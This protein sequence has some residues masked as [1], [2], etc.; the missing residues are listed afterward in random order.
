MLVRVS[1]FGE[2]HR[3]AFPKATAGG[4]EFAAVAAAVTQVTDYSDSKVR[5]SEAGRQ[6]KARAR[7]AL[8][9]RLRSIGRTARIIARRTPGFADPFRIP[10]PGRPTDQAVLAAGRI[11]ADAAAEGKDRFLTHGLPDTFVGDLKRLVETFDGAT[12]DREAGKERRAVAHKGLVAALSAGL[13]AA[14]AL[15]VIVANQLGDDGDAMA[16]WEHD[17][18][19]ERPRRSRSREV[20]STSSAPAPAAPAAPAVVSAS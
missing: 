11:F 17:R 2:A 5:S 1:K 20:T 9:D 3:G 8:V 13:D 14:R 4:K 10:G 15:D 18:K 19:V 16:A 12:R 7:E 6:S